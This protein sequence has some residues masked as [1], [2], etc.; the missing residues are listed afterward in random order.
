M[1]SL[2][3]YDLASTSDPELVAATVRA[4]DRSRSEVT[5]PDHNSEQRSKSIIFIAL[6]AIMQFYRTGELEDVNE[7][8]QAL[9]ELCNS[10]AA[11]QPDCHHATAQT[12]LKRFDLT[13][14][15]EDLN[16]AYDHFERER[17]LHP[18]TAL[19]RVRALSSL[20]TVLSTRFSFLGRREDLKRAIKS[21][22]EALMIRKTVPDVDASLA[23]QLEELANDLVKEFE[24]YEE[25]SRPEGIFTAINYLCEALEL[26]P[27]GHPLRN[28]SLTCLC[29]ALTVCVHRQISN[30]Q[31][32]DNLKY[33]H[34]TAELIG[35]VL[36]ADG[37]P[38][39][40]ETVERIAVLAFAARVFC[41]KGGFEF[42][43]LVQR[44]IE[45]MSQAI[46]G[47][48]NN[49]PYFVGIYQ[50]TA[51]LYLKSFEFDKAF[52][53]FKKAAKHRLGTLRERLSAAGC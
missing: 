14:N 33:L 7:S 31:T 19:E 52:Q 53:H 2:D 29:R 20:G 30:T 17:Q 35:E 34:W 43:S 11:V 44:I 46:N 50:N 3:S 15:I 16:K 48:D 12:F 22:E 24:E 28:H 6:L 47:V 10:E 51:V 25:P 8:I 39:D 42:N 21:H 40:K 9:V 1:S 41:E 32:I 36:N 37:Q 5:H 18:N 49:H 4:L 23:F 26:R 13:R 27:P 38:S 45:Y